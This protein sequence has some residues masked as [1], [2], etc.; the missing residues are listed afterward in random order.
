MTDLAKTQAQWNTFGREFGLFLAPLKYLEDAKRKFNLDRTREQVVSV[1][2]LD[3]DLQ[4]WALDGMHIGTNTSEDGALFVRVVDETPVGGATINV[5]KALGAGSGDLVMTGSGA[6]STTVT[7]AASNNSGLTG[8]VVVGVISASVASDA[9]VV[10][11]CLPDF[12]LRRQKTFD[13]SEAE[14]GEMVEAFN[15]ACRASVTAILQAQQ[16]W[17]GALEVFLTGRGGAFNEAS[18]PDTAINPFVS[19]SST[20]DGGVIATLYTGLLENIVENMK[21][22]STAE[23]FVVQNVLTV[24]TPA[25]DAANDGKGT[26]STPTME[27]WPVSGLIQLRCIADAVGAEQFALSV[28]DRVTG[29]NITAENPL[30]VKKN[31]SDGKL[32]I[33]TMTL[34]R[35]MVVTGGAADFGVVGSW[36][37]DNESEDNTEDGTI[38][39]KITASGGN[40]IMAGY[41]SSSY[42][43][44]DQVFTTAATA[45]NTTV[46]IQA[47]G[48]SGLS[49]TAIIGT[50]P[51]TTTEGNINLQPFKAQ[52]SDGRPDKFTIDI[53]RGALGEFQHY[54]ADL[55]GF[56]LNST[57]AGSETL[58]DSYV[59]AG[60]FPGYEVR[61]A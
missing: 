61:D 16:A 50:A 5:Y 57:T 43:T 27:D 12:P 6:N 59:S 22:E 37:I 39:L 48:N 1:G 9:E 53:T 2:S 4:G 51:T 8:T 21:D 45:A 19:K 3:V 47:V 7:L 34:T 18:L 40:W 31:Y 35:T 15:A 32:G 54:L 42:L 30:M 33:Q 29:A 26:L 11:V 58:D 25:A 60:T 38:Y 24:G 20:N 49:G 36:V 28:R 52:N 10:L 56:A 44:A 13:G 55:V 46:A 23:Q 14:H 41:S 17:A